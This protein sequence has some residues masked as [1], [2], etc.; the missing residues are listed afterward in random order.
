MNKRRSYRRIP[1]GGFQGQTAAAAAA[2]I[3]Q[4]ANAYRSKKRVTVV[5]APPKKKKKKER[6]RITK[7]DID[8]T[9]KGNPP[10]KVKKLLDAP[11]SFIKHK[12]QVESCKVNVNGKVKTGTST[13]ERV[14]RQAPPQGPTTGIVIDIKG[15]GNPTFG[16]P[17]LREQDNIGGRSLFSVPQLKLP[18][19]SMLSSIITMGRNALPSRSIATPVDI[20][21]FKSDIGSGF[22]DGTP[23]LV[24]SPAMQNTKIGLNM[25]H[26]MLI[27]L[28]LPNLAYKR[29][30]STKKFTL[31][32]VSSVTDTLLER[33]YNPNNAAPGSSTE[34]SGGVRTVYCP[35]KRRA[36]YTISNIQRYLD[37]KVKIHICQIKSNGEFNTMNKRV[38]LSPK[39]ALE[40]VFN[41]MTPNQKI[42]TTVTDATPPATGKVLNYTIATEKL[43]QAGG[44][45]LSAAKVWGLTDA[46]L[47]AMFGKYWCNTTFPATLRSSPTFDN[48]I[49]IIKS[50]SYNIGPGCSRR[51]DVSRHLNS[52]FAAYGTFTENT[53][54]A[55]NTAE[56]ANYDTETRLFA[57]VE[58]HGRPSVQYYQ[59]Q[60][61]NPTAVPPITEDVR[62]W[63][64]AKSGP[65]LFSQSLEYHAQVGSDP[66]LIDTDEPDGIVY[67]RNYLSLKDINNSTRKVYVEHERIGTAESDVTTPGDITF[68][69]PVNTVDGESVAAGKSRTI[70]T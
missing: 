55:A 13:E 11:S 7:R 59:Y 26:N 48:T 46:E 16:V 20:A 45:V 52:N 47:T 5:S 12:T 18:Q 58:V 63:S 38:Y 36:I 10:K 65:A 2:L 43:R 35:H 68:I 24:K 14:I 40:H 19:G 56:R 27:P 42:P 57:L 44:V 51:I 41:N 50:V 25:V 69:V 8:L 21:M 49:N 32:D 64:V 37:I 29:L 3:G 6:A 70:A 54:P 66:K 15:R 28:E 23:D 31:N 33:L 17:S 22:S 61:A 67:R 34:N 30:L 9:K 62:L 1:R 60:K 4:A 39:L 53:P